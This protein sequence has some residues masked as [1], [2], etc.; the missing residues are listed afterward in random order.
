LRSL[1]QLRTGLDA[2]WLLLEL[3]KADVSTRDP[4]TVTSH[5]YSG[6]LFEGSRTSADWAAQRWTFASPGATSTNA[7]PLAQSCLN[8]RAAWVQ[9]A[10]STTAMKGLPEAF[11]LIDVQAGELAAVLRWLDQWARRRRVSLSRSSTQSRSRSRPQSQRSS[12]SRASTPS[13]AS[14]AGGSRLGS[15]A[16]GTSGGRRRKACGSDEDSDDNSV[17]SSED[18]WS[19]GEESDGDPDQG[20]SDS[21]DDCRR[22]RGR[23]GGPAG[24]VAGCSASN[25]GETEDA[26]DGEALTNV[27]VLQGP[28]GSGKSATVHDCARRLGY[29]VIEVNASQIRSGAAVRKTIA[30]AA[31][32]AHILDST[33]TAASGASAEISL[34]LFDEVTLH[35]V[36]LLSPTYPTLLWISPQVDI[37]FEEEGDTQLYSAIQQIAQQS[38]CPIVLTTERPLPFFAALHAKRIAF[39]RPAPSLRDPQMLQT[40]MALASGGTDGGKAD[41]GSAG[42]VAAPGS[43]LL[44]RPAQKITPASTQGSSAVGGAKSVG[45]QL[46][47]RQR[48][49]LQVLCAVT[50][51][52][53][54]AAAASVQ[55][56]PETYFG[57]VQLGGT[58][59]RAPAPAW[60][61]QDSPVDLTDSPQKRLP[62]GLMSDATDFSETAGEAFS[63]FVSYLRDTLNLDFALFDGAPC[64][65]AAKTVSPSQPNRVNGPRVLLPVV[66]EVSPRSGLCSG[67]FAVSLHGSNFLQPSVRAGAESGLATVEVL[68]DGQTSLPCVLKS[69]TQ[70]V[71][72]LPPGCAAGTHTLTVQVHVG[73]A[74][75]GGGHHT[76]VASSA[77][78]GVGAG[79][80]RLYDRNFPSLP[81]PVG[82][83]A[84]GRRDVSRSGYRKTGAQSLADSDAETDVD[85]CEDAAQGDLL[86]GAERRRGCSALK[87]QRSMNSGDVVSADGSA[88]AAS[89][90]VTLADCK[91]RRAGVVVLEE[92][93][94]ESDAGL[95]EGGAAEQISEADTALASS[96]GEGVV[97][98]LPA[99]KATAVVLADLQEHIARA[100]RCAL[101]ALF[102]SSLSA[103]FLEPVS[104]SAVPGYSAAIA[105]PMDLGTIRDSLEEGL[106]HSLQTFGGPTSAAEVSATDLA[107]L[108][109]DVRLVWHNCLLFN[110]ESSPFARAAFLLQHLFDDTLSQELSA[111]AERLPH[112]AHF[113]RSAE[114]IT[115]TV[116]GMDSPVLTVPRSDVFRSCT[117]LARSLSAA[118]IQALLAESRDEGDAAE[119]AFCTEQ[120]VLGPERVPEDDLLTALREV[121]SE[122]E[123]SGP[124]ATDIVPGLYS[125]R[126]GNRAGLEYETEGSAVRLLTT[127][128]PS[129]ALLPS[130]EEA[131]LACARLCDAD[132]FGAASLVYGAGWEEDS[133]G[134]AFMD[135]KALPSQPLHCHSYCATESSQL[136]L[137]LADYGTLMLG[138]VPR[139]SV[140][141]D[142]VN[143]DE[144]FGASPFLRAQVRRM[145]YID[146]VNCVASSYVSYPG[147]RASNPCQ[148]LLCGL[149]AHPSLVRRTLA[150]DVVPLLSAMCAAEMDNDAEALQLMQSVVA[151]DKSDGRPPR[152]AGRNTRSSRGST[153][154]K[155]VAYGYMKSTLSETID[156]ILGKVANIVERLRY[157]NK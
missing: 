10:S 92:G 18:Q 25:S 155:Y 128:S 94:D 62:A 77:G 109:E 36:S 90:G 91:R 112:L 85:P 14:R 96:Q 101:D 111:V 88:D 9:W 95:Q 68:L 140:A 35:V 51:G 145:E 23:S 16:R 135:F 50:W 76:V 75:A 133:V 66:T 30:E 79:W 71:A 37:V 55:C 118:R 139:R 137:R 20:L 58:A 146:L 8:L 65:S 124:S 123:D 102:A 7:Y 12:A 152:G 27:L 141:P 17:S 44:P 22:S 5:T 130:L 13:V 53:A 56:V 86:E 149:Q 105:R 15:R 72:Y 33:A 89:S 150:V 87:R 129:D 11:D 78:S 103:P 126:R 110:G 29:R 119:P 144:A 134:S 3:N 121:Q 64:P 97:N 151:M 42:G 131:C 82:D 59:V 83:A 156:D 107:A 47:Q 1:Q 100:A 21:S 43:F 6:F 67:G 116:P 125:L 63:S 54:R 48:H 31:Q 32:S 113:S 19:G 74:K 153:P 73:V 138:G 122:T 132:L 120:E 57:P 38:K 114:G 147:G 45:L 148:G 39:R 154:S 28:C 60:T 34:I 46:T 99:A 61:S 4:E 80:I 24:D 115:L 40:V 136:A 70:I 117:K 69:A 93:D 104:D 98:H 143:S 142:T 41:V 2:H 106:Y 26:E 49:E 127:T 81:R 84:P 52:D 108:V 157:C